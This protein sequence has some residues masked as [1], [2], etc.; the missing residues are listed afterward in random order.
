LNHEQRSQELILTDINYKLA[1]NP[2][3]PAY[4]AVALPRGATTRPL[5]W[6][7]HAGGLQ[8]I[9]HDGAGFA[10]DNEAPRHTVY[11]R[12]FRLADRP[13]TN[14]EYLAFLARR[15]LSRRPAP[16]LSEGCAPAGA[17]TGRRRCTGSAWTAPGGCRR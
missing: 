3:H 14:G 6:R 10:F 13:V 1:V 2:L 5:G 17:R 8:P 4:H 11:L 12:P 7:T 16:W 9:G 15:R